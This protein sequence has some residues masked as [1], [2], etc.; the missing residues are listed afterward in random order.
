M[1]QQL[2]ADRAAGW[3]FYLHST[4]GVPGRPCRR[5]P[6]NRR[7]RPACMWTR[8]RRG[9]ASAPSCWRSRAKKL[10]EHPQPHL[11]ALDTNRRA[12][13]LYLRMGYRPAGV[14]CVYDPA[15]DPNATV[16]CR[17]IK[18]SMVR[19]TWVESLKNL[20]RF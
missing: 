19:K 9:R 8:P 18:L 7:D 13:A 17:E 11:Y 1:K 3:A 20:L 10:A 2:L 15:V 14:G 6:Q 12:I 5:L 16:L 4:A